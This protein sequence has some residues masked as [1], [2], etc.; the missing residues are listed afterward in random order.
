MQLII[1]PGGHIRCL[2]DEALDLMA[3]GQP[4]IRRGSHV[5][6]DQ[7]GRWLADLSPV[8]GPVLGPF[9]LRSQALEAERQWLECHWLSCGK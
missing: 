8:A 9:S 1:L 2:Y 5:E 4:N 6:P 3:I 7:N